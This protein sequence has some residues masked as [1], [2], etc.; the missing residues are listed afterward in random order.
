MIARG[1]LADVE[2]LSD[3][4]VVESLGDE[5]QD[6]VLAGREP[7]E[8]GTSTPGGPGRCRRQEI[9]ERLDEL[10]PRRL[11]LQDD[12]VTAL[13]R[14]EPRAGYEPGGGPPLLEPDY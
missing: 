5:L 13:E 9:V 8:R 12:M 7:F 4:I 6:F 3:R 14:N 2:S 1:V 10:L 11:G